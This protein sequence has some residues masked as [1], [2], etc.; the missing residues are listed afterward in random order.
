MTTIGFNGSFPATITEESYCYQVIHIRNG[1]MTVLHLPNETWNY[2]H[3]QPIDD[4]H[5]LLV[6]AR[7]YYHDASNIEEQRLLHL[8]HV[9]N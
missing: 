4:D 1:Q 3:V 9:R 6:C 8:H 7:S 2:H 5:I